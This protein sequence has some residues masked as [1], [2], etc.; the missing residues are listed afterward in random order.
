MIIDHKNTADHQYPLGMASSASASN[1]PIPGHVLYEVSMERLDVLN[2]ACYLNL[3][4]LFVA[5]LSSASRSNS[6]QGQCDGRSVG[7]LFGVFEDIDG[8][9]TGG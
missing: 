4:S 3:C 5:K 9:D 2:G 6:L 1:T 8:S 7:R